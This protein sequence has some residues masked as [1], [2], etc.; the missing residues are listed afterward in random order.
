MA[1]RAHMLAL[2]LQERFVDFL[3]CMFWFVSYLMWVICNLFPVL[4]CQILSLQ[5]N[6]ALLPLHLSSWGIFSVRSCSLAQPVKPPAPLPQIIPVAAGHGL[7]GLP[8]FS[9]RCLGSW[10]LFFVRPTAAWQQYTIT[11]LIH[12]QRKSGKPQKNIHFFLASGTY[13]KFLKMDQD[14]DSSSRS[15]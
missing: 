1:E 6:H 12:R 11:H 2:K 15:K 8:A 14:S 7:R 9:R 5:K 10:W 13:S 3:Q 4:N